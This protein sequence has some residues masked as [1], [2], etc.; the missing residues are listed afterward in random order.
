MNVKKGVVNP[1]SKKV[2]QG[3]ATRETLLLA[4]RKLFG[5]QGYAATS[6]DEI[7]QAAD[8]TKGAFYHHFSC[9]EEIFLRVFEAVK[10]E[11]SRAAFVLDIDVILDQD[12]DEVWRDLLDRCRMFIELHTDPEVRRIVLL[13]A[14]SVLTW[15]DWRKIENEYGVVMLRADLR[16]AMNR[17]IIK[18]LP[19]SALAMIL[20]GALNEAC[21]LVANAEDHTKALNEALAIIEQFLDGL[22][23]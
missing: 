9:K 15:D 19:L 23:V 7:V 17:G 16:R 22:R 4:A 11:L 8:V 5:T 6:L 13:D 3:K 21:M 1:K 14:R 18:P 10:K 20:T 2:E 12:N